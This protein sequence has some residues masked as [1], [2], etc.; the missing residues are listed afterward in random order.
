MEKIEFWKDKEKGIIDPKLFSDKAE[1]LAKTIANDCKLR[2]NKNK[3]KISQIRK[4]Y[5]EVVRLNMEAKSESADWDK[6]LPIVNMITAKTAYAMGRKLITE[7]FLVFIRTSIKQ[8]QEPEDLS[9]FA[10][11]F[12][13]FYGFYKFHSPENK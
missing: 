5:D 2:D 1:D 4:F 3:N 11:L 12:E 9:V 10:N 7:N 13:A 8:I 6:I